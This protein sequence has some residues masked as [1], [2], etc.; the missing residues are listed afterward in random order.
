MDRPQKV[1]KRERTKGEGK[2]GK[3]NHGKKEII[4]EENQT[5]RYKKIQRD[6][7]LKSAGEETSR[8]QVAKKPQIVI[9]LAEEEKKGRREKEER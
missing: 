2:T 9:Q 6:I 1:L 3:G 7:K 5:K 4:K 8:E